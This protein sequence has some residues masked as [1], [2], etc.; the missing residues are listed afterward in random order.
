MSNQIVEQ[1]RTS[2]GAGISVIGF[3]RVNGPNTLRGFADI[4]ITGWHFRIIGCPCHAG[5]KG[6]RWIG[7]PGKPMTDGDGK[8]LRDKSTGKIRYVAACAFDDRDLLMRFSD[9][10]AAALD[11]Y[12]PGWD[13]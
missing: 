9:A 3:N 2:A 7:L 10:A 6:R 8:P 5:D 13:R 4:H 11:H 1:P 12:S